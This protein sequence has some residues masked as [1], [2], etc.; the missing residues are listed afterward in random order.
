MTFLEI[1]FELVIIFQDFYNLKKIFKIQVTI[2]KN[3]FNRINFG[4]INFSELRNTRNILDLLS[5]I[6]GF[7]YLFDGKYVI[8][9]N[10]RAFAQKI[11]LRAKFSTEFALKIGVRK[12]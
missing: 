5:R 7:V 4:E 10:F 2:N 6:E 3:Y 9:T 12:H 8:R 11:Y 1:V